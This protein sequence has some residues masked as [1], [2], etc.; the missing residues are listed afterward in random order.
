MDKRRFTATVFIDLRMAIDTEHHDILLQKL[1][2]HGVIGLENAW[3]SL[4]LKN[5]QQLLYSE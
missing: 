2:K 5:R 3:F 1:E 4:Y